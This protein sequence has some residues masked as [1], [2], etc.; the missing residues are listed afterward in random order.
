MLFKQVVDPWI[1]ALE[2]HISIG[3]LNGNKFMKMTLNALLSMK[4]LNFTSMH[5]MYS[6]AQFEAHPKIQPEHFIK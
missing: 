5:K 1:A 3:N 2:T 4:I 6:D